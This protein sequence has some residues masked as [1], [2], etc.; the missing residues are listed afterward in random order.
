M[1][2]QHESMSRGEKVKREENEMGSDKNVYKR[3]C[4][5]S[6]IEYV[7]FT[8]FGLLGKESITDLLSSCLVQPLINQLPILGVNVL[9]V[10]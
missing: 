10:F 5:I 3:K 4:I 8:T 7:W 1:S 2:G 9:P 6:Y